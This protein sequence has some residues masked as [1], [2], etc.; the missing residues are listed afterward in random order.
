MP[1]T[2]DLISSTTLASNQQN[3]SFSSIPQTYSDLVFKISARTNRAN[4]IDRF[5]VYFNLSKSIAIT[6]ENLQGNGTA[7]S[8]SA[9][10]TNFQTIEAFMN[11]DSSTENAF[12]NI[13]LY[14]P[15]Y[16]NGSI[17]IA[18][19]FNLVVCQVNNTTTAYVNLTAGMRNSTAA[20]TDVTFTSDYYSSQ[21]AIGS[22]FFLYGIKQ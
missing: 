20:I 4:T 7:A 14:I 2:Y 15:N 1:N 22:S 9:Q 16:S 13:E 19:P 11:A 12:S 21:F 5:G 6:E 17:T 18:K 10:T 3:V 8:A